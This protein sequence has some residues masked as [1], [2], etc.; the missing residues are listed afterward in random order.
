[1]IVTLAVIDAG[2]AFQQT[3][4]IPALPSVGADF[5][6][7]PSDVAWLISGWL[8]VAAVTA[9][10]SGKL[11]DRYGKRRVLTAA[12]LVFLVGSIGA[13]LAPTFGVLVAFRC[14]QGIGGAIFPLTL[15]VARDELVP[16]R[17]DSA[18]G[19]LTGAFGV[20]AAMGYGG[21]GALVALAS[22][23]S[24]F[25]VGA[26]VTAFGVLLVRRHITRSR[27]AHGVRINVG[28]VTLLCAALLA[29]LAVVHQFGERGVDGA[30]VTLLLAC[31]ACWWLWWR[32]ETRT[33]HPLLE[34]AALRGRPML[35][36]N[37]VSFV[38]GFS[39]F[40]IYYTVPYLVADR[41]EGLGEAA[42]VS[43]LALLPAA[44]G[45]A[46]GGPVGGT[47]ARATG[48]RRPFVVGLVAIAAG[49][50]SLAWSHEGLWALTIGTLAL[51]VGNG[52]A[53]GAAGSLVTQAAG[54]SQVAIATT[55]NGVVRLVGSGCGS[56]VAAAILAGGAVTAGASDGRFVACFAMCAAAAAATIP[57]AARLAPRAGELRVSCD[58][59]V[60]ATG[61]A[62]ARPGLTPRAPAP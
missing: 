19:V 54:A 36:A 62:G 37:V 20:G 42:A 2:F 43:S 33:A 30:S 4:I 44:V 52:F 7:S 51:G 13:A 38:V 58:D 29:L 16:G 28:G 34:L 61:C 12:L 55:F 10:V 35:L 6:V 53:I 15:S 11:A 47:W 26:A 40:G 27:R 57:A 60:Q 45:L 25:V 41:L 3:V 18:V 14:V 21:S 56:Q 48:S 39:T 17:V 22:W 9:P 24:T 46:I 31:C 59:D 49:G 1:M 32:H 5:D 8:V 50:A 23:R